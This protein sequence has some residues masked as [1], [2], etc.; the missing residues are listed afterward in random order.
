MPRNQTRSA[1]VSG[2]KTVKSKV[3]K[4]K[5]KN[6][7]A[8]VNKRAVEQETFCDRVVRKVN[9][10]RV[11][12][13]EQPLPANS[14]LNDEQAQVSSQPVDKNPN[15]INAR[16]LEDNNFIDMDISGLRSTFPSEDEDEED[17]SHEHMETGNNNNAT[18]PIERN[19]LES[20]A[21]ASSALPGGRSHDLNVN[22]PGRDSS[23]QDPQQ[24]PQRKRNGNRFDELRTTIS[25][26]QDFM[27]EKGIINNAMSEAEMRMFLERTK[28]NN[29]MDEAAIPSGSSA[30]PLIGVAE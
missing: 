4:P 11:Q 10:R 30:A 17:N 20:S 2:V 8:N 12:R 14:N 27:V 16:I 13:G 26:M 3:V 22:K 9:E 24:T 23:M 18:L 21:G 25:L 1:R 29:S 19:Q 5:K 7:V 28:H 6:A 15:S